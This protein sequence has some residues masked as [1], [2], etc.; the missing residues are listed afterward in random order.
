MKI[1]LIKIKMTFRI[2]EKWYTDDGQCM[3]MPKTFK[4]AP[5][6]KP[7]RLHWSVTPELE[8]E[9]HKAILFAETVK[10]SLII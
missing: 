7:V 9:I 5:T 3:P 10:D 2:I 6:I 4:Q 1:C 8:S